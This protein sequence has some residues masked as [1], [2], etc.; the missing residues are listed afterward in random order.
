MVLIQLKRH[1]DRR[2]HC[3]TRNQGHKAEEQNLRKR[4]EPDFDR[5]GDKREQSIL[6]VP[7]HPVKYQ[8]DQQRLED[9]LDQF[10]NALPGEHAPDA[11]YRIHSR[12]IQLHCLG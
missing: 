2:Y 10:G 3:Q 8:A 6:F 5:G 1:V 11:F 4:G 12:Q 7:Y 9:G